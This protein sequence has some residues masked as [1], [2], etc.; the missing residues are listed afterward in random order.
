MKLA[1]DHHVTTRLAIAL[2]ERDHDVVA[3]IEVGWHDLED[4]ALFERCVEDGRALLTNNA[5]DFVPIVREW[6]AEG[7]PHLGLL[8]TDDSS[9]PRAMERVGRYIDALDVLM[10][11]HPDD[12]ALADR[13]RWL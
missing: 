8:L 7:R 4:P 3:A 1:L 12:D 10:S 5:R 6:A 13:V 9:W 2:R 11:Q